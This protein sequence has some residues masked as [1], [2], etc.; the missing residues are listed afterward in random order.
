MFVDNSADTGSREP[1][2]N[3]QCTI[4]LSSQLVCGFQNVRPCQCHGSLCLR[5]CVTA[6]VGR[7]KRGVFQRSEGRPY[8]LTTRRAAKWVKL[9]GQS[10]GAFAR[11]IE[12]SGLLA[13]AQWPTLPLFAQLCGWERDC[14]VRNYWNAGWLFEKECPNASQD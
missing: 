14:R 8:A 13:G 1:V 6:T 2:F 11:V 4:F 9:A 12:N 3:M 10:H 7:S 5:V